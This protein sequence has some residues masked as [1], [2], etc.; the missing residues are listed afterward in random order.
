MPSAGPDPDYT[1]E[2]R[3]EFGGRSWIGLDD[4]GLLDV[5]GTELLLVGARDE[6]IETGGSRRTGG[7]PQHHCAA[8]VS[9][10]TIGLH[11]LPTTSKHCGSV[12]GSRLERN[13]GADDIRQSKVH[14]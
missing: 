3:E 13:F 10:E 6:P 2:Q 12:L 14:A 7:R 11:L 5:A 4:R 8:I 9:D 1:A